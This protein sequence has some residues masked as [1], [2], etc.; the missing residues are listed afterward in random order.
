LKLADIRIINNKITG[1]IFG[2]QRT[3]DKSNRFVGEITTLLDNSEEINIENI[4]AKIK[5]IN[6]KRPNGIS[7]SIAYCLN[8]RTPQNEATIKLLI[9]AY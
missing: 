2:H 1:Q 3:N 5:E 9:K 8:D 7:D 4:N 6:K